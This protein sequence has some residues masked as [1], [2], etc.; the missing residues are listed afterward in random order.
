[1]HYCQ[2]DVHL[3]FWHKLKGGPSNTNT[4]GEIFFPFRMNKQAIREYLI[5]SAIVSEDLY[6]SAW[7][8][9]QSEW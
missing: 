6:G 4:V 2:H 9:K 8:W 1:M 5:L 7:I 3:Y